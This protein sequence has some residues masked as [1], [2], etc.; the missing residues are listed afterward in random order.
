MDTIKN[1]ILTIER[2]ICAMLLFL[3]LAI[4]FLATLGRYSGWFNM[5]W[6]DEAARYAMVWVVFM[7]AGVSAYQGDL[8]NVDIIVDKLPFKMRKVCVY[9][10]VLLVAAFCIFA[11]FYGYLVVKRQIMMNQNSPSLKLPMWFMYSSVPLGCLLMMIHYLALGIRQM[12]RIK[13]MEKEAST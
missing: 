3:M 4:V 5:S 7:G 11:I 2:W 12:R 9:I 1:T 6:G 13:S 10:R 8:F